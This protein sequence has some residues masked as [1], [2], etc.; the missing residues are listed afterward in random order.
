MGTAI[1]HVTISL[2]CQS[3]QVSKITNDGLTRSGTEC[4]MATVGV[5]VLDIVLVYLVLLNLHEM[6]GVGCPSATQ[7]SSIFP[8][9]VTS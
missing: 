4:Y 1:M 8:F 6:T 5:K 7:S 9:T 2:E 3:A